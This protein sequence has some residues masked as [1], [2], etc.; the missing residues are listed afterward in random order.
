MR[1]TLLA[2]L[3]AALLLLLSSGPAPVAARSQAACLRENADRI[4][5]A[6]DCGD[7]G[8]LTHCLLNVAERGGDADNDLE[9]CYRRAGCHEAEARI[10]TQYT[11][12]HHCAAS[13]SSSPAELR[14]RGPEP[15]PAPTPME[16]VITTEVP[17]LRSTTLPCSTSSRLQYTSCPTQSTGPDAGQR[18]G[19]C[20]AATTSVLTCADYALCST[21]DFG[22]AYCI[23]A[24]TPLT[25][26]GTV[27]A[28]ALGALVAVT[29]LVVCVLYWR[30]KAAQKK[31]LRRAE[32]DARL[33]EEAKLAARVR[34]HEVRNE[35][36]AGL[37]NPFAEPT[38]HS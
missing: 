10:N 24:R 12:K 32:A 38:P 1:S 25:L 27:A 13:S 17:L 20:Y 22:R 6:A 31:K 37:L 29:T 4:A 7:H 18:L 15:V 21:N 33:K 26:S 35:E 2:S 14:R 30:E 5:A 11:L 34:E 3:P 28:A 16:T 19:D 36:H 8:A 9:A 23:P